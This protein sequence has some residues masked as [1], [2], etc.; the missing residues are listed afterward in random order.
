MF[1][2]T[3]KFKADL[4]DYLTH[5]LF[6]ASKSP[7]IARKRSRNKMV[8]GL[9]FTAAGLSFFATENIPVGSAFV[10]IALLWFVF[11][12]IWEA[13]YFKKKMQEMLLENFKTPPT[14]QTTITLAK[15]IITVNDEH[16]STQIKTALVTLIVEIP[17]LILVRFEDGKSF[18]VPKNKVENLEE[19]ENAL[20]E[21]AKLLGVKYN[22][23]RTWK[24][25]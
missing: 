16:N 13:N 7:G 6:I 4:E 12:P 18:L 15:D 25:K 20:H 22:E 5:Q 24:W 17:R 1:P 3:I 8:V 21:L 14:N 23:E 9:L 10:T 11:Y 2:V 19:F